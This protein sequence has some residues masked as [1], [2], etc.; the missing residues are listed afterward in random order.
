MPFPAA[1]AAVGADVLGS[2]L[3]YSSANKANRLQKQMAQNSIRWRVEDAKAAGIHPL[4][5]LGAPVMNSSPMVADFS[6]LSNAGQNIM[7]AVEAARDSKERAIARNAQAAQTAVQQ[8]ADKL[9]LENMGLQNDYLR[10]QIARLGASQVPPPF[11]EMGSLGGSSGGRV[12]AQPA[13][14]IINSPHNAA[15]EAGVVTDFGY[16]RSDAGGLV[17]VPSYD[18][19]QRTEDNII[20]EVAWAWRNQMAPA[21]GGLRPPSAREFPLPAGFDRWRW[22][23]VH[24]QFLPYDS[25]RSEFLL[26]GRRVRAL[27]AGPVDPARLRIR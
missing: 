27:H 25:R 18:V 13:T 8:Q 10:S 4:Y 24:Q 22:S 23:A 26:S 20:Q 17:V 6:G 21:I 16:A 7:R 15:R 19:K 9:Q 5:A 2:A 3:G 11:P 14:P 12:Q 1:A